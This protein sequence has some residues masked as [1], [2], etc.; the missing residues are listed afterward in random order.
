VKRDDKTQR[1]I[2]IYTPAGDPFNLDSHYFKNYKN[3][4]KNIIVLHGLKSLKNQI[5]NFYFIFFSVLVLGRIQ[6]KFWTSSL[7]V[8]N[9]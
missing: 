1:Y 2:I 4:F 7:R 9:I 8:I 6:I 3:V 5:F